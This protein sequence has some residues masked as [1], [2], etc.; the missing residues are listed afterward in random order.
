[1]T[2]TQMLSLVLG[3]YLTGI[4]ALSI[5]AGRRVRSE[6]DYLIAG[7]RLP[8]SLAWATLMA[9]WFGAAT[10]LGAA[11]AAREEGVRG[12]LLDPFAS[13]GALIIAGLFF[14]KPLWEMRLLTISDFYGRT[15]GPKSEVVA[16][17]ITVPGY[18]GWVAA[19]YKALGGLQQAFFGI[20][21]TWGIVLAASVVLIYTVV[22]GMWSVTLT[23]SLQIVIALATLV[24][25]AWTAFS[26]LGGGGPA[27]GVARLWNETS[28]DMLTFL[29]EPGLAA[30]LVWLATVGSGLFGNIPGQDLMQRVFASKDARTAVRACLLA[31]ALYVAFGLLPV[32]LGLASKLLVPESNGAD[33][34]GILAQ[35]YLTPTLTVV[36]VV[37]LVSI[38]VS[39]CTSAVLSPA[40]VLGHNLLSRLPGLKDRGLLV[41]RSSVLIVTLCSV[42]VAYSDNTIIEL[43]ELSLSIVLVSLFVPLVMGLYGS[44]K[45]RS[46]RA[47]LLAMIFGCAVWLPREGLEGFYL[48]LPDVFAEQ[49]MTYA[50]YIRTVYP[51]EHVGILASEFMYCFALIPSAV[52]GTAASFVGY[53]L[54]GRLRN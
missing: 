16:S 33:I 27:D 12:T 50:D 6:E 30:G 28:P 52:S 35:E 9:T 48:P 43:L 47:A 24:I 23:D 21:P 39:T 44:R 49:G 4:L 40:A 25:L 46:E 14:A 18:F 8:L 17:L 37:A 34:L 13:G 10:V 31:G 32:G 5:F 51:A 19:Q 22:G 7:R 38:I 42:A 29:P 1:M 54:G 45:R 3:A 15:Y 36:F 2:T 26:H 11:E 41:D 53:F 20:D